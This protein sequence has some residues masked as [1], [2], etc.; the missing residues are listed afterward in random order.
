MD[1]VTTSRMLYGMAKEKALPRMLG[2]VSKHT[3]TPHYAVLAV[4]VLTILFIL[5]G[6]LERI[7]SIANFFTFIT[8]ATIN[9]V[10]IK[11]RKTDKTKRSFRVPG[12]VFGIP[13]IPLLGALTSLGLLYYVF[14]GII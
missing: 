7:A 4:G 6:D 8:F 3:R 14:L 13:I 10:V 11:L 12:T 5:I 1:V 9:I 2:K